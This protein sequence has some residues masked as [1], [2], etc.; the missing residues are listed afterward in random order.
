MNALTEVPLAHIPCH[1]MHIL[2]SC[3]GCEDGEL[4]V[5][6]DSDCE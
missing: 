2:G 3:S 6:K 4:S 1:Y 5:A